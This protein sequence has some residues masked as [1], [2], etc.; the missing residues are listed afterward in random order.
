M[1]I[2]MVV[3]LIKFIESLM[4]WGMK[5]Y[6]LF[7]SKA[8]LALHTIHQREPVQVFSNYKN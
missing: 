1:H 5:Y 7:F 8:I 6:L 4:G 2:V 3:N